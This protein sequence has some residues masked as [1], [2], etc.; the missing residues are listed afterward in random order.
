MPW[1]NMINWPGFFL[2][3]RCTAFIIFPQGTRVAPKTHAPYKIGSGV[4]YSELKQDCVP[5]AT[6]VGMLWPKSSILRKPGLA[7]IEFLPR[8]ESGLDIKE[9]MDLIEN[10]IEKASDNLINE[11]N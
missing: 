11:D 6:N 1:G 9:F 4:L 5:V 3:L 8:I 2:L 7:V 10:N